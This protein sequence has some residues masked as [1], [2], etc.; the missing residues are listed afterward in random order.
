MRQRGQISRAAATVPEATVPSVT[1][2]WPAWAT[3]LGGV[4]A[5]LAIVLST[6]LGG[7]APM[8]IAWLRL[9]GMTA[10]LVAMPSTTPAALALAGGLALYLVGLFAPLDRSRR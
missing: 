6:P 9:R 2:D 7:A 3:A 1:R 4:G 5:G 10:G 8:D